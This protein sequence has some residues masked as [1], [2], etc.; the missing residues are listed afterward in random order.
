[1]ALI[2]HQP[3]TATVTLK[4]DSQILVIGRREFDALMHEMPSVRAQVMECLAMRLMA[5]ESG[6]GH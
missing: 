5:S 6:P 4:T 3:R 1:M 2:S